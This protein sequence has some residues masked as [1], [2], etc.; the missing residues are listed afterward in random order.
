MD[1]PPC[2]NVPAK[3][4]KAITQKWEHCWCIQDK[5]IAPYFTILLVATLF[6]DYFLPQVEEKI[7]QRKLPDWFQDAQ[8]YI[9]NHVGEEISMEQIA[10]IC[11]KRPEH[12]S[13]SFKKYL[14]ITPSHYIKQ[15]RLYHA[16]QLLSSTAL[17]VTEVALGSGFKNM[18]YFFRLFKKNFNISPRNYRLQ[19]KPKEEE[20][21]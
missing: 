9:L 11:K 17:P 8:N 21:R 19:Y 16:R 1:S 12:T 18:S 14:G 10:D 13:R 7:K 6:Y 4:R 5:Q 15:T 3:H 20:S 2:V